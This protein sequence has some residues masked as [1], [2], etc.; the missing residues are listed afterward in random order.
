LDTDLFNAPVKLIAGPGTLG[1]GTKVNQQHHRPVVRAGCLEATS[2]STSAHG[3]AAKAQLSTG[4]QPDQ[5]GRSAMT[6][7]KVIEP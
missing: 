2:A 6:L 4:T 1:Q 7:T 5:L 3:H